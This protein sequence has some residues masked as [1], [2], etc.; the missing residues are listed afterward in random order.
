M[1]VFG[2]AVLLSRLRWRWGVAD[3]STFEVYLRVSCITG[4]VWALCAGP[5]GFVAWRLGAATGAHR[6]TAFSAY[7]WLDRF[8]APPAREHIFH[9]SCPFAAVVNLLCVLYFFI[10][11]RV[12]TRAFALM[13]E[14]PKSN[15]YAS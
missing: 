4:L 3:L 11:G 9:P 12:Q 2:I 10:L 6:R 13:T 5:L 8:S 1:G 14:R 7:Y 15:S